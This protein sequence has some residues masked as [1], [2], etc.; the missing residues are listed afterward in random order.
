MLLIELAERYCAENPQ[1]KSAETI[2]LLKSS[3]RQFCAYLKRP[4]ELADLNAKT[5]VAYTQYRRLAGKAEST[6][7]R[8]AA[9][10]MTLWRWAASEGWA[11]TPKIRFE[12]AKVE[13][14]VCFLRWE[15]RRLVKA[16]KSYDKT[17]GGVSG[18][19]YLLALLSTIWDTA[20]R[21]G[22]V[23]AVQRSDID[24]SSRW[25]PRRYWITIRH[26][27]RSGKTMVRPLRRSTAKYLRL[28]LAETGEKQPFA[29]VDRTA[30]YGH[31]DRVLERAGLPV[32]RKHKF[33]CVRRSH[34]SYLKR[35]GGDVQQ[36]LDHSSPQ[37]AQERYYDPRVT[38]TRHAVDF[39]FNPFG[40]WERLLSLV[41]L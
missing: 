19:V 16:M 17:I 6:I 33:H 39:L 40:V 5:L 12:K 28:L 27:K 21:I 18:D 9:K 26:R 24:V 31:L 1:V 8:E 14:P 22:A 3:V 36:S 29:L 32:D 2:R 30:L 7:E 38:E 41:G 37:I 13:A 35:A 23:R 34:A 15:L 11:Q 10:L 25:W 4:A 20:E